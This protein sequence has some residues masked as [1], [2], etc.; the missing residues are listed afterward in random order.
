MGASCCISGISCIAD[1]K[2]DCLFSCDSNGGSID[3]LKL[4]NGFIFGSFLL[5]LI[6][7]N[8]LSSNGVVGGFGNFI[9][10]CISSVS[11]PCS[12]IN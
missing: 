12:D 5:V 11:S 10:C 4:T 6:G 2:S 8:S 1:N 7:I 3:G 9:N